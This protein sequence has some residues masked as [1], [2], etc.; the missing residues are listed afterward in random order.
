MRLIHYIP[1]MLVFVLASAA[2]DVVSG[3][4]SRVVFFVIEAADSNDWR[5]PAG[6][7]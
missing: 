7:L 1:R 2:D 4:V 6:V 5:V 3:S